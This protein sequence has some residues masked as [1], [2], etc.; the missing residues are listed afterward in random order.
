M[1]AVSVAWGTVAGS[2]RTGIQLDVG[3]RRMLGAVAARRDAE[4]A[5]AD[6]RDAARRRDRII[7]HTR[8]SRRGT[9]GAGRGA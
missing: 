9:P 1:S 2:Q 5:R 4:N 8:A 3:D 6:V 7:V